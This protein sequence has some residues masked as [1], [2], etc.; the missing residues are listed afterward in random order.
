MCSNRSEERSAFAAELSR[1][2]ASALPKH[3][4]VACVPVVLAGMDTCQRLSGISLKL[5]AWERFL[6]EYEQWRGK[7]VL[8]QY[9]LTDGK[10]PDDENRTSSEVGRSVST[11]GTRYFGDFTPM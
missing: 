10:R 9:G 3:P 5:L 4:K 1:C 11:H 7:V 2:V 6:C 8:V